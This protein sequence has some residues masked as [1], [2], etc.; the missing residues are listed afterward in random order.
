MS[1]LRDPQTRAIG[2][3]ERC[4]VLDAWRRLEQPRGLLDAQDTRNLGAT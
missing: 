1:N 2:H 4:L 3:A